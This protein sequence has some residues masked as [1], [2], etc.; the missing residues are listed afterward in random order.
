MG[1]CSSGLRKDRS[2]VIATLFR[3]YA[4][5]VSSLQLIC[6]VDWGSK[7]TKQC[8]F[9]LGGGSS[10]PSF[11]LMTTIYRPAD[12]DNDDDGLFSACCLQHMCTALDCV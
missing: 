12:Y 9:W 4:L 6:D 11:R 1:S 2:S 7:G 5:R 3:V 8:H 10:I